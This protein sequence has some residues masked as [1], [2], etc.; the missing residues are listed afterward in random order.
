MLTRP[1][2]NLQELAEQAGIPYSD[3]QLLQ[4]GLS[5]TRNTRDFEHALTMWEELPETYKT[6]AKCKK[7]FYEFQLNL[8]KR[9]H[10][11]ASGVSS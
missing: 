9:P 5:I 2:E 4:E 10:N 6:W 3:M 1:I 11:A 8:K 7:H